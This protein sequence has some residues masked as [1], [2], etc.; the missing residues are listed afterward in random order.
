MSSRIDD[1]HAS[2]RLV[3]NQIDDRR[4]S[5]RLPIERDVRYTVLRR[6][7]QAGL[8]KT[9]NMSAGGVLF[10]T[11]DILPKGAG[12][13]LVVSWPA[14]LDGVVPMKLVVIGRLVRSDEMQAALVIESYEFKTRGPNGL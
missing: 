5:R 1:R 8:G 12:V 10:T 13:E 3:S 6:Q 7:G 11:K 4:A 14:L 2:R 9:V